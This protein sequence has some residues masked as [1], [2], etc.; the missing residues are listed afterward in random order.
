MT[1]GND[2]SLW[3]WELPSTRTIKVN[4]DAALDRENKK[5]GLEL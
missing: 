3:R 4:W 2:S 1:L 5:W